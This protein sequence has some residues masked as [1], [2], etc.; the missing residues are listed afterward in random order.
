M[1]PILKGGPVDGSDLPPIIAR[2]LDSPVPGGKTDKTRRELLNELWKQRYHAD[3]SNKATLCPV[4]DGKSKKPFIL[5][6]RIVLL[7]SLVT[8]IEAFNGDLL[9]LLNEVRDTRFEQAQAVGEKN[10]DKSNTTAAEAARLL[11]LQ[12][13]LAELKSLEGSDADPERKRELQIT[14]LEAL[15]SGF[16][17]V[18]VAADR[19]QRDLN[20]QYDVVLA[21]LTARRDRFLQRTYDATFIETGTLGLC[22]TWNFLHRRGTYG[23]ELFLLVKSIGLLLT[24]VSLVGTHGGWRKKPDRT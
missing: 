12:P 16:L 24:T 21:Q 23:S 1:A 13:V 5:S 2:Y 15:L 6:H 3:M 10:A 9:S 22:A 17:D 8:A 18:H 14:L 7:W 20:Y 11:H 19:C 4:N